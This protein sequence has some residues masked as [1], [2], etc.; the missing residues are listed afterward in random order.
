LVGAVGCRKSE[1]EGQAP[2]AQTATTVDL[3]EK[4]SNAPQDDLPG[5][6]AGF[7]LDPNADVRRYGEG[8][9]APLDSVCV[10]LFNGECETYKSYGLEGVKTT[11]YVSAAQ[12]RASVLVVVS[13]FATT[14]GAFGFFTRRVVGDGLPSQVTVRPL[15]VE[16]RGAVGPGV[17]YL[18]RGKRVLEW[19]YVS[20]LETPEE[21]ERQSLIV[22]GAL[23]TESAR[24]LVGDMDPE[25]SVRLLESM[26]SGEFGVVVGSDGLLGLD[27]SGPYVTAFF[28]QAN[29]EPV[30]RYRLVAAARRDESAA[31]D[32]LQLIIRNVPSK[33]LKGTSN[34]RVRWSSEGQSPE[35]W[36]ITNEN[37]LL[38]AVAPL[39]QTDAPSQSTP[40]SRKDGAQAWEDFALQRLSELSRRAR[41]LAP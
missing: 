4:T 9:G 24:L 16:G 35:T 2:P 33:K 36:F 19:T 29:K 10:E 41:S 6:I 25:P 34:Y 14:N 20:E 8:T 39:I 26:G 22:L 37:D 5:R 7:C 12:K 15:K 21:V 18:W 40:E 13:H 28:E 3:C 17:A 27:G 31:K 11:Q 23:A 30:F 38:L 32:L 1:E